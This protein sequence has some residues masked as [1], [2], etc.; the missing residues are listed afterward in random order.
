MSLKAAARAVALLCYYSY[1]PSFCEELE[2]TTLCGREQGFR[3]RK[4]DPSLSVPNQCRSTCMRLYHVSID[5][6]SD[7]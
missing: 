1:P 5:H 6:V 2:G 4:E 7:P 3:G